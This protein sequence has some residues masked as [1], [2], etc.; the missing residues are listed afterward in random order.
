MGHGGKTQ[1]GSKG[2]GIRARFSEPIFPTI[3]SHLFNSWA[4]QA[5]PPRTLWKVHQ[6][7]PFQTW[8]PPLSL[9]PLISWKALPSTLTEAEIRHY[10]C[11]FP[12]LLALDLTV[13]WGGVFPLVFLTSCPLQ[14]NPLPL[15]CCHLGQITSLQEQTLVSGLAPL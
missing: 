3:R 11:F 12:L 8:P 14:S 9:F 13:S 6:L 4:S 1:E 10:L 2:R 15:P 7:F 5:P